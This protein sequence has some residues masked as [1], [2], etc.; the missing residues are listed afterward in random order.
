MPWVM[1][2]DAV[3]I[4]H[5]LFVAFV[6][7]GLVLIWAGLWRGWSWV[8]NRRFRLL[9]LGAIGFVVAQAW[10]GVVCPLTTLENALRARAGVPGYA[11][12]FIQTWLYRL[13]Y[14]EGS[15]WVFTLA[16]TAFGAAVALT[17]WRGRPRTTLGVPGETPAGTTHAQRMTR[18]P[19][20][21]ST[22]GPGPL[23]PLEQR[24]LAAMITP[25][26]PALEALRAQLAAASVAS[27]VHS[28]VG[29]VTRFSLPATLA[30]ADTGA[31]RRIRPLHAAHPELTEP[32][33]FLLQL[34]DGRL[35]TL[36]AWCHAGQWPA[37]ETRFAVGGQS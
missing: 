4:L 22:D 23:S 8:R 6:V 1:L 35:A 7:V 9:H 2:A 31:T 33:E 26:E 25:G 15:P 3:L 11:G 18:M 13:L 5:V 27:R 29:F 19:Q 14:Y 21:G 36:E 32:A 10:V 28:G 37:D 34:R 30:A 16:Y 17:W 20:P 12:T 24:V